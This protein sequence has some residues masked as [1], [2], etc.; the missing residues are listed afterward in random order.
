VAENSL[1]F[2][3]SSA[4]NSATFLFQFSICFNGPL[5]RRTHPDKLRVLIALEI[6][7]QSAGQLQN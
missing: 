5:W 4:G 1:Q 7:S 6:S 3:L 2:E